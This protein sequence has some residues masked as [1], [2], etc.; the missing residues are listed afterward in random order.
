[1]FSVES[2]SIF[3]DWRRTNG[4]ITR[5]IPLD[6][7]ALIADQIAQR[8][9]SEGN[10]DQQLPDRPGE[11]VL[12]EYAGIANFRLTSP[13]DDSFRELKLPHHK[14]RPHTTLVNDDSAF[15]PF[16]ISLGGKSRGTPSS[17]IWDDIL[18]HPCVFVR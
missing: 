12:L 4:E 1:M 9:E 3:D 11:V 6:S 2:V 18:F 7:S 15:M 13:Y 14:L 10:E 17:M 8:I 5:V 16:N